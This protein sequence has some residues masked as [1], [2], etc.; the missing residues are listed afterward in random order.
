MI[1]MVRE[2]SVII[3]AIVQGFSEIFPI[4]SSGHLVIISELLQTPITFN[5]AVFFHMGTFLAILVKYRSQAWGLVSGQFGWRLLFYTLVCFLITGIVGFGMMGIADVIVSEKIKLITL[6]WII[7]GVILILIGS[8]SPQGKRSIRD[9]R[10]WEFIFIGFIQ[11]MTAIPGISRLGMTLGAGLMLNLIWFEALDL[12]FILSLP[13]IFFAN[14][15][16]FLRPIL[17]WGKPGNTMISGVFVHDDP[18]TMIIVFMLVF[19]CGL[20][21]IHI[22]YK[23]LSKKLLVF[24]GLYCIFAG[25][26][27]NYFLNLF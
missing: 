13:T 18:I 17:N 3:L 22:L 24:F 4:S 11:G 15:F 19:F 6:L 16:T 1:E 7:N 21:S 2:W 27:F 8:F 14:V 10:L 23:Y 25:V 12:S 26:F 20:A 5:L 9:L